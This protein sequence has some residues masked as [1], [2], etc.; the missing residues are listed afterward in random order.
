MRN[1]A[2][3]L[4][5]LGFDKNQAWGVARHNLGWWPLS[6]LPQMHQALGNKWLEK[7]GLKSMEKIYMSLQ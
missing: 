1:V 2:H 6:I 4:I 7:E 5:R 3:E